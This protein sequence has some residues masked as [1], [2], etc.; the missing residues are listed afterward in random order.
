[1]ASDA[2]RLGQHFTRKGFASE[3]IVLGLPDAVSPAFPV[4]QHEATALRNSPKGCDPR[5][6]SLV[7]A[8]HAA[9]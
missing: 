9:Q 8:R 2:L 7:A 6:A 4:H 1:M 5:P 3:P